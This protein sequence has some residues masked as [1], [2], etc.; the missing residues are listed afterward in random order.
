MIIAYNV[1]D[2]NNKFLNAGKTLCQG[3]RRFI[4]EL[5]ENKDHYN[6]IRFFEMIRKVIWVDPSVADIILKNVLKN[7]N[8][9]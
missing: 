9:V 6:E 3:R 4:V 5:M 7:L 2:T 1:D 8:D